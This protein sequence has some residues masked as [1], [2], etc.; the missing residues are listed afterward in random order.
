MATEASYATSLET[1][2]G[3]CALTYERLDVPAILASVGDNGAGAQALFIGT[4][5]DNFQ[6][7]Q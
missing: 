5:R 1:E 2:D 4:T 6:G 7:L 3:V